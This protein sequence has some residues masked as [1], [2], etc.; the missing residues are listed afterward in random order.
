MNKR[1]TY[2]LTGIMICMACLAGCAKE[3]AAATEIMSETIALESMEPKEETNQAEASKKPMVIDDTKQVGVL[4]PNQSSERWANDG[5]NMEAKLKALGYDVILRYANDDIELQI[6]QI[7]DMIGKGVD[8]LVVASIDWGSF[9]EIDELIKDAGIP[10]IAYDRLLM[11]IDSVF[12]YETF[13]NKGIGRMI[14]QYIEE[15][16]KLAKAQAEEQSYTIE[17]FMGSPDDNNAVMLY[18]GVMEIL[19]PYFDDG[20]LV[21]KSGN[22]SFED[23]CILRYS[24]ETARQVCETYLAEYY[25][26]EPLD[27]VCSAFDGFSYGVIEA[28]EAG[29]YSI[30]EN[31]PLVTGQDAELVAVKNILNGYQTMSV[32]KDTRVLADKCVTMVQAVLEGSEPEI[33][34]TEQ[35]NNHMIMVPSYLCTPVVVDIDNYKEVMIDSGYYTEEQLA[36]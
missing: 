35:Y 25:A 31:W 7:K 27:I 2:I 10:I 1:I 32:H 34:D 19:Q 8:C 11:D 3:E 28:L 6:S 29:G 23:T 22:T 33:N 15:N 26:E 9:Q 36:E 5:A 12:Y 13:D 14:G 24:Q 20:T 21:C 30:E 17:L 4:M 16:K 18:Q